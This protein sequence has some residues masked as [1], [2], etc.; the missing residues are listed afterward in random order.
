MSPLKEPEQLLAMRGVA[1][2]TASICACARYYLAQAG[3]C[4]CMKYV[5]MFCD[6][7]LLIDDHVC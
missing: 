1:S 7:V 3:Y 4:L 6:H 2:A 5:S